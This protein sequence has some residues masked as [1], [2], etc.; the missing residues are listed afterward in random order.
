MTGLVFFAADVRARDERERIHEVLDARCYSNL[1]LILGRFV[2]MLQVAWL[3]LL[4]LACLVQLVAWALAVSGSAFGQ[5]IE[6]LA[7]FSFPF[8]NAL[9]AMAFSC[10]LVMLISMLI[11]QRIVALAVALVLLFGIYALSLGS[12]SYPLKAALDLV[13][14]FQAT[15]SSDW[16]SAVV[17]DGYGYVQRLA[18]LLFALGFLLLSARLH[19]RLDSGRASAMVWTALAGLAAAVA[20]LI[21]VFWGRQA[22]L[23]K[24][25]DWLAA[26]Q[27][28]QSQPAP[29]LVQLKGRL[30]IRPGD[31]LYA[32]LQLTVQTPQ[33]QPLQQAIFTLNPALVIDKLATEEGL[34]LQYS[35]SNGLLLFQL[36]QQL[37]PG[38]TL[39]LQ[40]VY[41]G[42]PDAQ[43]GYLD[44]YLNPRSPGSEQ[45]VAFMLGIENGLFDPGYVALMPGNFWLPLSGVEMADQRRDHFKLALDVTVPAG[46]LTAG[47]G[48]RTE[49]AADHFRYTTATEVAEV[50]LMAAPFKA[51]RTSIDGIEFEL[52]LH[53]EHTGNISV[54]AAGQPQIEQWIASR[55]SLLQESGLRYPFSA[56]SLVEVPNGLRGYRGGWRNDSALAPP[57]MVLMKESAFPS[58]R[59]DFDSVVSLGRGWP[60][61]DL[62]DGVGLIVVKR[63]HEFFRN[64]FL[65]GNLFAGFARSVFQHRLAATGNDA[66]ALD[67]TMH[68]LTTLLVSEQQ[69]Y[70]FPA[71]LNDVFRLMANTMDTDPTRGTTVSQRMIDS[72]GTDQF[73]W[74]AVLRQPLNQLNG[75]AEPGLTADLLAL[76]A[77]GMAQIIY[78]VLGP[79]KAGLVVAEVLQRQSAGTYDRQALSAAV[80]VFDANLAGLV[81]RW[82]LDKGLAGFTSRDVTLFKLPGGNHGDDRYQLSLTINNEETTAGYARLAWK[83]EDDKEPVLSEPFYVPAG[84][85]VEYGL[86]LSQLPLEVYLTPYV[87]LNRQQYLVARFSPEQVKTAEIVAFSGV[88]ATKPVHH[89]ALRIVMDDLSAEVSNSNSQA[90]GMRLAGDGA[91]LKRGINI[92]NGLPVSV[93]WDARQ[94]SRRTLDS[95]WGKYRRTLIYV[96]AG[97]GHSTAVL[98]ANL[99]QA[100]QWRLEIHIPDVAPVRQKKLG[101]LSLELVAAGQRIPLT[102]DGNN[103]AFGWNAVGEFALPKGEVEIMLSDKTS[104][105][106]MIFDAMA[107]HGKD[108]QL[109]QAQAATTDAK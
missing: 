97:Q 8:F 88:R 94:W 102:F 70:F 75:A 58:A 95:A 19:P 10:A 12:F 107:L 9:P 104:G 56:F 34:A 23:E 42:R 20:L 24:T 89:D 57:A 14:S 80:R 74:D 76:K 66:A 79:R 4:I 17:Y 59:F 45:A 29:D 86:T 105:E 11:R 52:L 30:D 13:G 61:K 87:A 1:E 108:P 64:D 48:K 91:D 6:P 43:F 106:L 82:Y 55:L 3:P 18:L 77:G 99:P 31:A 81:E 72:F 15:L 7:L 67:Y 26:H 98:K 109:V 63:L 5:P 93:N 39:T 83:T 78:Q 68:Q 54:L 35:F 21:T 47:P 60:Q 36:P 65:G 103:A 62:K 25:A 96:A 53:P 73:V 33:T 32:E 92:D 16:L 69:D 27:A 84:S 51:Y 38:Q 71:R 85:S 46:W 28:M 22:V 40:L 44:S 90:V 101:A 41:H 2:G 49:V 37:E 100:G 50:A